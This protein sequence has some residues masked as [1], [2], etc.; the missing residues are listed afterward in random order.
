MEGQWFGQL[1]GTNTGTALLDLDDMGTHVEGH[2]S[3]F[4][5]TL[6]APQV[7]VKIKTT[8][9]A[10]TQTL[11]V[12]CNAMDINTGSILT[13]AQVAARYPGLI[14]PPTANLSMQITGRTM[15]VSWSTPVS[16]G[17]GQLVL[18]RADYPSAYTGQTNVHNWE[19]F[20][21]HVLSLPMERFI[22]RGQKDSR[23]LRTAF[24][25]TRRKDLAQFI[26]H[27][28]PTMRR[29]LA[30]RPS[31]LF[32]I[33]KPEQYTALLALIQ[34]HGYPTPLLDWTYS[35]F[36]AA[37]FAYQQF[38]HFPKDHQFVRIFAFDKVMWSSLPQQAW[39]TFVPPHLS[40][41]EP[42]FYENPRGTPQQSLSTVTNMD[43]IE[44]FIFATERAT[45]QRYLYVYDLPAS[46]AKD[47]MRELRL[48]GIHAGS[49]F[50]GIQGECEGLRSRLFDLI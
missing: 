24:H 42:L 36:V 45:G 22:F 20:K 6:N 10:P 1:T 12:P 29:A 38:P 25:R 16:N 13:P 43:D 27:D 14:L 19:E 26:N 28:I 21:R 30:S 41:I 49:M 32:D 11:T 9:K 2:G 47:A 4:D 39:I 40:I 37:F 8:N 3:F 23:R 7:L 18:S 35:P 33:T 5:T 31:S 44:D 34:H 50:P 17:S 48:M 15:Q 46:E